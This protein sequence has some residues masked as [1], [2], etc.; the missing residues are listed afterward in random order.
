MMLRYVS[1]FSGIEAAS[2]AWEPLGW[3]CA[4]VAEVAP[5]PR[6]VLAHRYPHV[7]NLGDITQ[8]T[9]L[10][11]ALLDPLD[12]IVFGSPC[13]DL[14]LA[15]KRQGFKDG[16]RSSLFFTAVNII[17]WARQ[18][19]GL[20]FALWENVPGAFTSNAGRD[21]AAVVEHLAG[22]DRIDIPPRG[23]GTEGCAVG[24][25]AMVEWAVLDAQWFGVAQ[26]RRRVFALADFG[27]W[28]RRPP[29]L[30]E[31]ESLRGDPPS[32]T[33]ARQDV[34]GAAGAGAARRGVAAFGGNDTA[35]A[36]DVAPALLAQPGS[37]WKGDFDSE[38]FIVQP[39]CVTGSVT[40]ALRAE[41]AD[42]SEDGTG[43]G[44]PL[45]PVAYDTTQITSVANRSNPQP[46]DPC[47]PLTAAGH[48]PLLAF[49]AGLS[50][51]Q[52]A[53][54]H[55]LAPALCSSTPTAVAASWGVRRLTPRE[56]ERLQ[57]F[58]DDWTLVPWRGKPA[59]DCPDGPRYTALGNSMAVPVMHWIGQRLD[60]IHRFF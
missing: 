3:Q 16:T 50:G 29:V 28:S 18:H 47:H 25:A 21:F 32:R 42:A 59:A 6:S 44:T 27:A 56:C 1:L 17:R 53:A 10:D 49:P 31:P 51:T 13:Q 9:E 54:T 12:L 46:G 57:G 15:G 52:V 22:L 33:E 5:F 11:I 48:P 38:A 2:S 55:D 7:P 4:A 20:R 40:H 45:V 26:R 36:I 60:F 41:G 43:R 23:W 8:V 34:A 35:G 58:P 14:S 24:E 19:C 30:L 37:G 39:V